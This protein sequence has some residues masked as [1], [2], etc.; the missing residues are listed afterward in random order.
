MGVDH[1]QFVPPSPFSV[2]CR[3]C[4]PLWL[5]SVFTDW[6]TRASSVFSHVG[7]FAYLWSFFMV[8]LWTCLK[9]KFFFGK[10]KGTELHQGYVVDVLYCSYDIIVFSVLFSVPYLVPP[11]TSLAFFPG[12]QAVLYSFS[13]WS[14]LVSNFF[15]FYK[16]YLFY[17]VYYS[18]WKNSVTWKPVAYV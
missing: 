13:H 8:L 7:A 18:W 15:T 17:V 2:I 16:R 4:R 10:L 14:K 1:E 6:R 3:P 12:Y 11:S 5:L 9:K